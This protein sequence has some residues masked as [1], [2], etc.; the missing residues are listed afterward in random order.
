MMETKIRMEKDSKIAASTFLGWN[1]VN[2]SSPSIKGRIRIA[3]K[4][5]LYEVELLQAI[6]QIIHCYVTQMSS[7]M[8]FYITFVY[9]MNQE[10]QRQPMWNELLAWSHQMTEAWC[11]IGDLNAIL[12]EE[13]GQGG[14]VIQGNEQRDMANFIE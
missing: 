12:Y 5:S 11:I 4:P 10:Q 3:W 1:W 6:D 14:N 8:K 13:D 9:G 7:N 2:N